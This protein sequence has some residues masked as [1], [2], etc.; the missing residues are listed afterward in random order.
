MPTMHKHATTAAARLEALPFDV[1]L[2][3][4][5]AAAPAGSWLAEALRRPEAQDHG[6]YWV[7]VDMDRFLWPVRAFLLTMR[8]ERHAVYLTCSR[9]PYPEHE[10]HCQ[11]DDRLNPAQQ[12]EPGR[13]RLLSPPS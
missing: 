2:D 7:L 8:G 1:V 9:E 11:P 13:R 10:V 6:L 5:A 3:E 4:S 12:G